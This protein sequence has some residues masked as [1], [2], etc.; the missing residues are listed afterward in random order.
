MECLTKL[1]P[2]GALKVQR[3]D[4]AQLKVP[5]APESS[6]ETTLEGFSKWGLRD[7]S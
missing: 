7:A 1:G 2:L 5:R 6:R 3:I 4:G